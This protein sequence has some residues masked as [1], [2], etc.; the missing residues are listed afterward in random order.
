MIDT[1]NPNDISDLAGNV[2]FGPDVEWL[3]EDT[4]PEEIDYRV[5]DGVRDQ[6][7]YNSIR[8]YWPN[9]QEGALVPDYAGVRAKLGHP[10]KHMQEQD[11]LIVGPAEHGVAGLIHLFGMESPGLTSS[12]AIA[13][14]IVSEE[15]GGS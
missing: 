12:M 1:Y 8:N 11:F 4:T 10:S 13:K 7:F 3:H 9:L 15:L 2:R 14:Y 5:S 6:L